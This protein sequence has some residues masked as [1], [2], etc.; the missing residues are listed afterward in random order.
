MKLRKESWKPKN[1]QAFWK[2]TEYG[3]IKKDLRDESTAEKL[4]NFTCLYCLG[5]CFKTRALAQEAFKHI[6]EVFI[7]IKKS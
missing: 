6:Q 1:L 7:N 5:N 2:I 4:V 3:F